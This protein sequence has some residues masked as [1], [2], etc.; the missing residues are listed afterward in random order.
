M[1][2]VVLDSN[3]YVSAVLFGGK[4]RVV[5]QLAQEGAFELVVSPPICSEVEETLRVKFLWPESAIASV[6]QSLWRAAR[7][8]V[9]R[10]RVTDCSDPDDNRVLECA[11][12]C[13]ARAIVTGDRHLLVLNPYRG[14]QVVRPQE[15]LNGRLWR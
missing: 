9:P 4:P 1:T 2:T 7:E 12:E 15:F 10:R 5:L 14:V 8:V 13:Q 3:I 6:G 11:L